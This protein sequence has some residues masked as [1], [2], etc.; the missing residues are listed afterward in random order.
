MGIL[1]LITSFSGF[2]D[3][4]CGLPYPDQWQVASGIDA[5]RAWISIGTCWGRLDPPITVIPVAVA[6]IQAGWL[7]ASLGFGRAGCSSQ[8][9]K[10]TTGSERVFCAGG[11]LFGLQTI[12]TFPSVTDAA[13][14]VD[15]QCVAVS[16]HLP[17]LTTIHWYLHPTPGRQDVPTNQTP[18][19]HFRP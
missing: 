8:K 4:G 6:L 16:H 19:H 13:C 7:D 12:F 5:A 15:S 9:A 17:G 18:H 10:R 3:I 14:G 11:K 2:S 1:T